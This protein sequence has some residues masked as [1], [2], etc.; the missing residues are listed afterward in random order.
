MSNGNLTETGVDTPVSVLVETETLLNSTGK[1][2]GQEVQ[3]GSRKVKVIH[4]QKSNFLPKGPEAKQIRDEVI[5]KISPGWKKGTK[6]VN[7]GLTREEE[8]L[9]LPSLIGVK[10]EAPD[11]ENKTK[12]FWFDLS[13]P[14]PAQGIEF[15]AGF[16][17]KPNG[18]DAEPI[19]I[20]G[21]IYYNVAR[22]HS[23][24]ANEDDDNPAQYDFR[25]IDVAKKLMEE[26]SE[27]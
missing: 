22:T 15:E 17:L 9:Y 21:Y 16:K 20:I 4:F 5:K 25:I 8:L 23:R 1:Y 12:L 3:L 7:R 2:F 19:D 24:V 6:D 27:F 26:E 11:W 14:I 10:P 13:I 18:I